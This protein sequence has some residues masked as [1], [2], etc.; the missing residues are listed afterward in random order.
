MMKSAFKLVYIENLSWANSE[1]IFNSNDNIEEIAHA[2]LL[3]FFLAQKV[4]W[5]NLINWFKKN[6]INIISKGTIF[7]Y[8]WMLTRKFHSFLSLT[9]FWSLF[10]VDLPVFYKLQNLNCFASSRNQNKGNFMFRI[11]TKHVDQQWSWSNWN[12]NETV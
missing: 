2:K 12:K 4:S 6:H 9:N 10:F 11:C 1:L 8:K 5:S 7:T 3:C